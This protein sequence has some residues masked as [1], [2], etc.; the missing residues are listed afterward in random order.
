MQKLSRNKSINFRVNDEEYEMIKDR[1]KRVGIS[2]MRA[3][4]LK[5]AVNGQILNIELTTVD[6]CA[7]LLRNIGNN[8]NQIAKRVK[9]STMLSVIKSGRVLSRAKSPPPKR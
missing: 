1:Q 5:M 6:E 2:N 4:L 3:Y 8:V 9:D 7:R